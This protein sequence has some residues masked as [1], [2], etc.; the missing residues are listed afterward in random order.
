MSDAQSKLLFEKANAVIPGGVNS[1]VRAFRAVGGEPVFVKS[2]KGSRIV[3]SDGSS[4]IDYVASWGPLI[5]GSTLCKAYVY[6]IGAEGEMLAAALGSAYWE[7]QE[8]TWRLL[9]G[10]Y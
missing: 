3:G 8:R 7:Y 10:V 4:Y 9:P 2:A 5:A 1:P 6:R